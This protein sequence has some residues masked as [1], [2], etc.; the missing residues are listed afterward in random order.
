MDNGS[1]IEAAPGASPIEFTEDEKWWLDLEKAYNLL[2]K[3]K[4]TEPCDILYFFGRSYFDAPKHG[5]YQIGVDLYNQGVVKK[6]I[7]P[8]TEGERFGET[9]SGMAHPGKTFMK[10]RLVRM[11]VADKNVVF[12]KPGF[13]TKE[14]GDAFLDYSTQNNL[15]RVISLT[16]PHQIVRAMLG[17]VRTINNNHSSID[18]YAAVPDPN[19]FDWGRMVKGSQGQKFE[20]VFKHFYEELSRISLYQQ[21]GD[22]ASFEELFNYL[23]TR[24][25]RRST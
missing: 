17:L 1:K 12:S 13:N 24:D 3:D 25:S 4:P 9:T 14:E 11:G 20:P 16:N 23:N 18:V 21:K 7:V 19:H 22:L 2:C 15:Y 8:G 5:F 10:K 6:I